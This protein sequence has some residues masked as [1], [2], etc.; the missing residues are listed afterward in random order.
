MLT[1]RGGAVAL[2]GAMMWLVARVIGSPGLEVVGLGLAALPIVALLTSRG[3]RR[4]LEVRRRVSEARVRPGTRV[5]VELDVENRSVASTSFLLLEDRLPPSLGRAARLVLAGLSGRS[6]QRVGYTVLPQARGRYRLGPLTVD[7]TD[8]YGL[9]R[10]RLEFDDG[11]EVLVTPEIEDLSAMPDPASGPSFGAS[12]ARQLL[13]VGDEY[14]TMRQYQQGD[15]LR[16]VHWPSV[17]RTGQLMI[18]Q[19]EAT[20]RA[21]GL[22][23]LDQR[24]SAIGQVRGAAFERAVSVTASVGVLLS[25]AGFQL[26]LATADL[27]PAPVTEER[28]LD[29]LAGIGHAQARTIAP[30]LAHLRGAASADTS[31]VYVSAPPAPTELAALLRAGSGFGPKLAILVDPVDPTTL[32][33]ERRAQLEGRTTQARLALVRAGWDCVTMPPTARLIERWHA[34]KDRAL[35]SGV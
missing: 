28:F 26:R 20:R 22:I 11:D 8:P 15:D 21:N 10:Q 18:R 32:P 5:T 14:H 24:Q 35:A 6:G 9:T 33:P 17:A 7:V 29:T 3:T 25:R 13:R 34:P 27:A 2:A 16:R 31:L 30:A 1:A 12:R 23:L 4:K 19:D